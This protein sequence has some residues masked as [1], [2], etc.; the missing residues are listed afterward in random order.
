[1]RSVTHI[2]WCFVFKSLAKVH[3]RVGPAHDWRSVMPK[4]STPHCKHVGRGCTW[5]L[6]MWNG[7]R[8]IEDDTGT[9]HAIAACKVWRCLNGRQPRHHILCQVVVNAIH[10]T[11]ERG[12]QKHSKNVRLGPS[13]KYCFALGYRVW[14]AFFT[15]LVA[16]LLGFQPNSQRFEVDGLL[17]SNCP[18]HMGIGNH[19]NPNYH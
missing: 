12:S 4:Y 16:H 3:G 8:M 7:F 10:L 13:S 15:P 14:V 11:P 9:V 6:G 17:P 1:M 19:T 2:A 5:D 18:F